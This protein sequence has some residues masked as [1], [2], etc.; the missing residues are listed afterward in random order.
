M[1]LPFAVAGAR[2]LAIPSGAAFVT[3]RGGGGGAFCA[4]I[5]R[6][7]GVDCRFCLRAPSESLSGFLA[8]DSFRSETAPEIEN[9]GITIIILFISTLI[10]VN[11]MITF[12]FGS[13][14]LQ[15]DDVL[16]SELDLAVVVHD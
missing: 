16:R 6:S 14:E 8:A 10:Q 9:I 4:L 7:A 1:L 5:G 15:H 13:T 2:L 3:S 12:C 11:A